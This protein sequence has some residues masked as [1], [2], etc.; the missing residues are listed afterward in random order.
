M[1]VDDSTI[2]SHV[3][4]IRKKFA[5]RRPG[6]RPHRERLRDGLP[7]EG[8]VGVRLPR[9]RLV[10]PAQAAA[11]LEPAAAHPLDRPAVRARAGA[12][13]AFGPG[14]GP[15][16][17][18]AGGRHHAQ[19]PAERA[20]L[21]RGLLGAR[22]ARARPAGAEPGAADRA[23]RADRTTGSSPAS[24]PN[25]VGAWTSA[26]T[27]PL[28]VPLPGR[29]PR[30]RRLRASSRCRTRASSCATRPGPSCR[31]RPPA[32]RARDAAGRV[33][34]LRG[35]RRRRRARAGVAAARGAR[36]AARQPHRGR[37][38]QHR[39]RLPG[40]AAHPALADR[41]AAVVRGRGRRRPGDAH[42]RRACTGPRGPARARSSAPCSCPR[43]RSAS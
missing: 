32:G 41:P 24:S 33:A 11:R 38:A 1:V 22:R 3:K 21:G 12:A 25:E 26:G 9:P 30:R 35:R 27:T 40:R 43:P 28:L 19:R 23:R 4:R 18:G 13:A 2:T 15:R 8:G 5:A 29:P 10:D 36:A 14:A 37:V 42:A 7:L 20:A 31:E 16:L 17:H 6:V 34:A 39:R